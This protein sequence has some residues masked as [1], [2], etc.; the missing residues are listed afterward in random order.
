MRRQTLLRRLLMVG[1]VVLV[2]AFVIVGPMLLSRA[3]R[4]TPTPALAT[5]ARRS[6]SA[7]SS[8]SGSLQN[9]NLVNVNFSTAG[10]VLQV[11][12]Q[13]NQTVTRGEALAKLND[14]SQ[15]ADLN[16]AGA[17]LN[18]AAQQ[19]A[20]ARASGS[21]AQIAAAQAQVAS[22]KAGLIT[23]QRHEAATLL[24]APEAG[25]VLSVNGQV[26]NVVTAGN[27]GPLLPGAGNV[28]A[29]GNGFI[30][31][32]SG[33]SFVLWAPFS[34]ADDVRLQL[35]QPG[36]V[37]VDA[38]PGLSFPSKV[39]L[40]ETSATAVNG[41]PEYY[42]ESTLTTTDQRLRNGQT[43]T[44]NVVVASVNNVLAV[45][46]QALFTNAS[47]A[48]QVD[49]WYQGAPVAT[50]VTVGLT[51]TTLTQITSGLQQGE[52]VMLS[53]VGETLPSSPVPTP[54]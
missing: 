53:P 39:T 2:L 18:A 22:A 31:I 14:Q 6:F 7:I 9:A 15:Q 30:V 29:A 42:A 19:L 28:G 48:L 11:F 1:G 44:V 43:A 17:Q 50:T 20:Q 25:S 32:G 51:G 13:A 49:V 40:I 4:P 33:S 12:V 36:T 47:G 5:V 34:Q 54:T 46:T 38:L 23:A 52:Q 35:G 16:F 10:T 8:A 45:P 21:S 37:T 24:T 27:T 41:V 26:G 3:T